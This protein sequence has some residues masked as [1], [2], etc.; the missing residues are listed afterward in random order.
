[1]VFRGIG[2]R[3]SIAIVRGFRNDRRQLVVYE[4][5]YFVL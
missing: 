4:R 3:K 5:L 2:K 1:M